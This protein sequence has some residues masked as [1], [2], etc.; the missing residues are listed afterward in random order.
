MATLWKCVAEPSGNPPGPPNAVDPCRSISSILRGVVTRTR[1]V[2]EYM[3]VLALCLVQYSK[4]PVWVIVE[5]R[6]P[7]PP[8]NSPSQLNRGQQPRITW[9]FFLHA[10]RK[11]KPREQCGTRVFGGTWHR[12]CYRPD[13]V[14]PLTKRTV[15]THW[16]K[17]TKLAA[18]L[19]GSRPGV[20]SA[21]LIMTS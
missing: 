7:S 5:G 15:S 1:N 10:S 14:H 17:L 20:Q 9:A 3:L 16:K 21:S 8:F 6:A 4:E 12:C 19:R 11:T 13:D 18:T 2:S